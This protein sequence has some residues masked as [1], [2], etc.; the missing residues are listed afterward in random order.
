MEIEIELLICSVGILNENNHTTN[1]CNHLRAIVTE[2]PA[3]LL[4]RLSAEEIQLEVLQII[5]ELEL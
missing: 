1:N 3:D 4:V 2:S 5:Q